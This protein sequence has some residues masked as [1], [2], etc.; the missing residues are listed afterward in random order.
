[1][2]ETAEKLLEEL[3]AQ[4]QTEGL[5][6]A[7]KRVREV[8]QILTEPERKAAFEE[9]RKKCKALAEAKKRRR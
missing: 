3:E 7:K 6:I 1:M 9:H 5:R 2:K 4:P 8:L